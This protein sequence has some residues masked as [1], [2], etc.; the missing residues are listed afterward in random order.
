M[1]NTPSPENS[2]EKLT[3]GFIGIGADGSVGAETVKELCLRNLDYIGKIYVKNRDNDKSREGVRNFIEKIIP[4][5]KQKKV[6]LADTQTMNE[7]CDIIVT[8]FE[9]TLGAKTHGDIQIDSTFRQRLFNGNIHALYDTDEKR[10]DGKPAQEG[11]INSLKGYKGLVINATNPIE[12]MCYWMQEL[13]GLSKD[14]IIGFLPDSYR[15]N[16]ECEKKLKQSDADYKNIDPTQKE[17]LESRISKDFACLHRN[18]NNEIIKKYCI[19]ETDLLFDDLSRNTLRE[20]LKNYF[21]QKYNETKLADTEIKEIAKIFAKEFISIYEN[22]KGKKLGDANDIQD[23]FDAALI[24][25]HEKIYDTVKEW[26]LKA[27]KGFILGEHSP[28]LIGITSPTGKEVLAK[29]LDKLESLTT[30]Y[31]VELMKYYGATGAECSRYMADMIERTYH[32]INS[33]GKHAKEHKDFLDKEY[34]KHRSCVQSHYINLPARVINGLDG[35]FKDRIK[36]IFTGVPVWFRTVQTEEKDNMRGKTV[37][38]ARIRSFLDPR[39]DTE[40]IHSTDRRRDAKKDKDYLIKKHYDFAFHSE[41]DPARLPKEKIESLLTEDITQNGKIIEKKEEGRFADCIRETILGEKEKGAKLLET[42][43]NYETNKKINPDARPRYLVENDLLAVFANGSNQFLFIESGLC[44]EGGET[45]N[46]HASW[47]YMKGFDDKILTEVTR[48]DGRHVALNARAIAANKNK[49]A[50]ATYG[51]KKNHLHLYQFP[52]LN[53][54]EDILENIR[55]VTEIHLEISKEEGIEFLALADTAVYSATDN[56]IRKREI[57][58]NKKTG[59]RSLK[60]TPVKFESNLKITTLKEYDGHIFCGFKNGTIKEFDSDLKEIETY[61]TNNTHS[62]IGKIKIIEFNGIKQVYA[63]NKKGSLYRWIGKSKKEILKSERPCFDINIKKI[64]N[65]NKDIEENKLFMYIAGDNND[66]IHQYTYDKDDN[67]I[68]S[69]IFQ[70]NIGSGLEDIV[71][72]KNDRLYLISTKDIAQICN[73]E[74]PEYPEILHKHKIETN[75][76][77]GLLLVKYRM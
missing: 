11:L 9:T 24:E 65:K 33:D 61:E 37:T 18:I 70:N 1:E 56:T 51:N 17:A 77:L 42:I 47:L 5:D 14:Q 22:K 29:D 43:L 16:L 19:E 13:I 30:R 49:L 40:Y 3:I 25:F 36:G 12:G 54:M 8:G 75:C 26:Q 27:G 53:S 67:L 66:K 23:I 64:F 74:K 10:E 59:S 35:K 41:I 4:L 73:L 55:N 34:C 62:A 71:A 72:T 32:E 58:T 28:N 48:S 69:R 60:E 21:M 50:V 15:F 38:K 31:G 52:H 7:E 46:T 45:K 44:K 6:K 68:L 57:E 63:M 39:F 20:N 76:L 2:L